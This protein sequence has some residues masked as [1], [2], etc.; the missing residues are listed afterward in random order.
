MIECACLAAWLSAVNFYDDVLLVPH[1][2]AI[3]VS[4]WMGRN[5]DSIID[6]FLH[7]VWCLVAGA[8]TESTYKRV[9]ELCVELGIQGSYMLPSSSFFL[10]FSLVVCKVH[11]HSVVDMAY[12]ALPCVCSQQLM[13]D[14]G[15]RPRGQ[16]RPHEAGGGSCGNREGR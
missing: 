11:L 6:L 15:S 2:L 9:A 7:V 3:C 12:C 1:S 8:G 16:F 5:L 14:V 4:N 13:R 10:V